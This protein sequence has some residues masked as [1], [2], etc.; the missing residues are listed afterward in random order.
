[1]SCSKE[2]D[3]KE[4]P[5]LSFSIEAIL[6]APPTEASLRNTATCNSQAEVAQ[7][8]SSKPLLDRYK[9]RKLVLVYETYEHSYP[10]A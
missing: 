10:F 9:G 1:M 2:C 7:K 8:F 3:K 4:K 5:I 6:K